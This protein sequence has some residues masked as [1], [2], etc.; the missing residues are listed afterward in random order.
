MHA[1]LPAMHANKPH[2]CREYKDFRVSTEGQLQ[3]VG[4]LIAQ[5]PASGHLVVLAPIKVCVGAWVGRDGPLKNQMA[6]N[7][8]FPCC[9]GLSR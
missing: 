8:C 7:V 2:A 9:V 4:L 1:H 5:D 6:L 3:G